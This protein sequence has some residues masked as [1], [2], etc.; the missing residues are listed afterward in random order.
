MTI[1]YNDGSGLKI[2]TPWL[3]DVERLLHGKAWVRVSIVW[4]PELHF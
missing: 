2:V 3:S 1:E 4:R